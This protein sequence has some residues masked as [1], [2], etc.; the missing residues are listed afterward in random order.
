MRRSMT[1]AALCV[2][3]MIG[4][5]EAQAQQ[6]SADEARQIARDVY[7][8]AYP[9]VLMDVSKQVSTNVREPNGLTAPIN[10]LAHGRTFPDPSFTIVVRPNADT[11]YSSLNF[12]V[13]KEPLII[14]V[15][16]S[17]G[18]FYLL[19]FLDEWTDVFAVPG[20]RTTGTTALTFAIVGPNWRGE[21][22]ADIKRYDSPTAFGWMGGRTQTKIGRAHV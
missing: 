19:P 17:G 12:D 8:Y 18:R 1:S 9:M 3:A 20:K 16:D 4:C 7:V 11:L 10:Q 13:S 2:Q 21:L 6:V 14:T 5:L 22:P 15:P